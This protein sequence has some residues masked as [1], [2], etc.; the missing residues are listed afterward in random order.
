MK[1]TVGFIYNF[2]TFL[3][4]LA[5]FVFVL[6]QA[7]KCIDK[8][9]KA[10]KTTDVSMQ[11]SW[12][13]SYP[14]ISVCYT[15]KIWRMNYYETLAKCNI[16]WKEYIYDGKYAS[17]A[18]E[19]NEDFCTNPATLYE[20]LAG[21]LTSL[22]ES[23]RHYTSD[24]TKWDEITNDFTYTNTEIINWGSGINYASGRCLTYQ[25][26][27]NIPVHL[28]FIKTSRD[29]RIY[30]HSPNGFYD[31]DSKSMVLKK[32]TSVTMYVKHD[33]LDFNGES[34][35]IYLNGRDSCVDDL[36]HEVHT[37]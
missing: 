24:L 29:A 15:N 10:P 36:I 28:L 21:N 9:I 4:N 11:E 26:P 18:G 5:C 33:V 7:Q 6:Y 30:I 31:N 25:V 13:Y 35:Q 8:F 19:G 2:V 37:Y 17:C 22:V 14:A 23:V 27:K 12:K 1:I 3:L 32:G 20:K 34:C 16:T